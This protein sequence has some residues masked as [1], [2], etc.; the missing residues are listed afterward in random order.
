LPSWTML[1]PSWP[2]AN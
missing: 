2:R 1:I